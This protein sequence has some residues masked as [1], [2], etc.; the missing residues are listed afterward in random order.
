MIRI[1]NNIIKSQLVDE[2]GFVPQ[3]FSSI[4]QSVL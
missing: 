3:H 4:L 2:A 1:I